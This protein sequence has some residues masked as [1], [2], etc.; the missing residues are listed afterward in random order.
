MP[1]FSGFNFISLI[2]KILT[3]SLF[4]FKSIILLCYAFSQAATNLQEFDDK[5]TLLFLENLNFN[6]KNFKQHATWKNFI[7]K[8]Y[9]TGISI[10]KNY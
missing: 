5:N 1:L 3:T 8:V 10:F 9:T 6:F 4:T 7:A 2:N